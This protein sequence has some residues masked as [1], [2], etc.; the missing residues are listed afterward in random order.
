MPGV[1]VGGLLRSGVAITCVAAGVLHLSAAADHRG[2]GGHVAFFVLV[3]AA[4]SALGASVLWARRPGRWL[5]V[6]AAANLAVVVVWAVSR[7]TGLP[8]DGS[9]TPEAMG[10]KD[11]VSTLFE[12]GAV[13]GA[14]MWW[15]LPEPARQLPLVSRRLASALLGTGVWALGA[16]G[17][18]AGHTHSAGH[19]H[20]GGHDHGT[21]QAEATSAHADNAAHSH[22]VQGAAADPVRAI[23]PAHEADH[24]HQADVVT[25]AVGPAAHDPVGHQHAP[26]GRTAASSAPGT[27]PNVH[28][29]HHEPEKTAPAPTEGHDHEG[30][31]GHDRASGGGDHQKDD[32]DHDHSGD[33]GEPRPGSPL[34]D[35]LKLLQPR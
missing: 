5:A 16:A 30:S 23:D 7:T 13:A 10:F 9:S 26:A 11:A 32:D 20:G 6:A 19:T 21:V 12:F 15:L 3:A 14:G 18:L 29:H 1:D 27:T 33:A 2:M 31:H 17:L 25:S 8:V 34:D 4:Q 35:V 28:G 24:A 22:G